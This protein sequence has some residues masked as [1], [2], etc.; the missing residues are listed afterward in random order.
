MAGR[1]LS[2]LVL[3]SICMG[4][5]FAPSSTADDRGIRRKDQASAP[6]GDRVALVIGNAAYKNVTPLENTINDAAIMADALKSL[7]FE[8]VGGK[9]QINLDKGGLDNVIRKFGETMRG[10]KSSFPLLL[11]AWGPGR[12]Q[13]LSYTNVRQCRRQDGRQV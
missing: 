12:R 3:A 5:P 7:G 2:I 4:L 11:R 10:K 1:L 8:L 13:E 9:A 6:A